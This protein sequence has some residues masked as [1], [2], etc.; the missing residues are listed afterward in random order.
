MVALISVSS[1]SSPRMAN[2]R[3]LEGEQSWSVRERARKRKR[4]KRFEGPSIPWGNS[5]HFQVLTGVTGQLEHLS[6]QVLQDGGGVDGRRG[7]HTTVRCGSRF[8]VTVNSTDLIGEQKQRR[9]VETDD[10]KLLAVRLVERSTGCSAPNLQGTANQHGPSAR[11]PSP[12]TCPSLYQLYLRPI[13]EQR[14]EETQ[15]RARP[16]WR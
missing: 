3:C 4:E 10:E 6:G 16:K 14:D 13:C 12:L 9:L 8:Q 5:L 11:R 7:T 2:C 1:S 15:I